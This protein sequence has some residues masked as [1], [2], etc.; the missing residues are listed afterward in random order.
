[1]LVGVFRDLLAF[2]ESLGFDISFDVTP[3][4]DY[5]PNLECQQSDRVAAET[6]PGGMI[7]DS[8]GFTFTDRLDIEVYQGVTLIDSFA[9]EG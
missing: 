1:V 7:L 3:N 2:D 4:V 8:E 9:V 5:N 6:V